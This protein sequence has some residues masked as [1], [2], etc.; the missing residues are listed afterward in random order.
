MISPLSSGAVPEEVE[1]ALTALTDDYQLRGDVL[2]AVLRCFAGGM[3]DPVDENV[4]LIAVPVD[5]VEAVELT[6]D[7]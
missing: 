5:L 3:V 6:L 4:V 7:P 1:K 2:Q